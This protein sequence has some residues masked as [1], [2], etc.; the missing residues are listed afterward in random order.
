M[1][2]FNKVLFTLILICSVGITYAI[3]T[4]KNIP[5]IFDWDDENE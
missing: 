2:R 3:I 5:D 1:K 4:L